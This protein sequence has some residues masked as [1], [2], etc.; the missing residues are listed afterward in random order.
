MLSLRR[1]FVF[2]SFFQ[3]TGLRSSWARQSFNNKKALFLKEP[4]ALIRLQQATLSLTTQKA[5]T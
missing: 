4:H 1:V 2:A 5:Q 3:F